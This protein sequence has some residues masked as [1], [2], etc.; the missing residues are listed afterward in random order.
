M[1]SL[2]EVRSARGVCSASIG[3]FE[4]EWLLGS[5]GA[6]GTRDWDSCSILMT[7]SRTEG[8]SSER[9]VMSL[10]DTKD[11]KV[12]KTKSFIVSRFSRI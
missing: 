6:V 4:K 12:S 8:S 9:E 1:V 11:K 10:Q 5:R 2:D 3:W 7:V